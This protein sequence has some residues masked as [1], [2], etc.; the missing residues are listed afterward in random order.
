MEE[1]LS[2]ETHAPA[3]G[4]PGENLEQPMTPSEADAVFESFLK[5]L[6]QEKAQRFHEHLVLVE[7]KQELNS[8][9][10]FSQY[11]LHGRR[12][13]TMIGEVHDHAW[14]CGSHPV[15]V[16][17]YITKTVER[18]RLCRV[19]LELNPGADAATIG[20]EAI[21]DTAIGLHRIGR[22]DA[23][24]PVD[25]RRFFLGAGQHML[26]NT[27]FLPSMRPEEIANLFIEPFFQKA[28]EDGGLFSLARDEYSEA[29]A[30]YLVR[31]Y[32]PQLEANFR[33]TAGRL[34]SLPTSEIQKLLKDDWKEV[35]DFYILRELLKE[36]ETDEYVLVIGDMH[37]IHLQKSLELLA[38]LIGPN[39]THKGA[40]NCVKL[41]KTYRV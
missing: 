19:L 28:R 7:D 39:Q 13:I 33:R 16:A 2:P 31:T 37:Y 22:S 17:D 5:Q 30:L 36:S 27:V 24:V 12:L 35:V 14:V 34:G 21:R 10:A 29:T 3:R 11:V 23:I 32:V 38:T 4:G 20:S 6:D 1:F 18:N 26:Y 40:G 25:V 41:F 8:A 9:T 15:S